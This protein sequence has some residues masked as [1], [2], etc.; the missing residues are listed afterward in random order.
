MGWH[1]PE[2]SAM[3]PG[4]TDKVS[5]LIQHEASIHPTKSSAKLNFSADSKMATPSSC[6]K[7]IMESRQEIDAHIFLTLKSVAFTYKIL[8]SSARKHLYHNLF[9][10]YQDMSYGANLQQF[11][12]HQNVVFCTIKY[13]KLSNYFE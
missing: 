13:K 7:K 8:S 1:F 11:L 5:G 3:G 12:L 10:K 2:V 6:Q 9:H 4:T